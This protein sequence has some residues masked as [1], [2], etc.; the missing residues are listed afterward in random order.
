MKPSLPPR[1]SAHGPCA[2]CR[3]TRALARDDDDAAVAVSMYKGVN[4]AAPSKADNEYCHFG[5][6]GTACSYAPRAM[7]PWDPF[8]L[9]SASLPPV[10]RWPFPALVTP[11]LP[12]TV[13]MAFTSLVDFTFMVHRASS[14]RRRVVTLPAQMFGRKRS[15]TPIKGGEAR[16]SKGFDS[17]SGSQDK[18]PR[19]ED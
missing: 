10:G 12:W 3:V 9:R 13:S 2:M 4:K 5:D 6:K 11:S 18:N 19:F 7:S 15:K 8:H 17:E 1:Q 16:P 14:F